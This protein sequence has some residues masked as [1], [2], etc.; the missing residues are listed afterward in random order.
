MSTAS[1]ERLRASAKLMNEDK[2][3]R[4]IL[5]TLLG[6]GLLAVLLYLVD[7]SGST[8]LVQAV[9]LFAIWGVAAVSLNLI[10]GTTG[11]LVAGSPRLHARRWL[12]GGAPHPPRG[13]PHAHRHERAEPDERLYARFKYREL[14]ARPWPRRARHARDAVGCA[15]SSRSLSAVWWRRCSASSSASRVC[16][17]AVTT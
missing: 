11:I 9:A 12:H 6:L 4:N 17:C 16:G 10:N 13:L 1:K 3:T 14:D 8:K 5:L 7:T 15:S 2:R